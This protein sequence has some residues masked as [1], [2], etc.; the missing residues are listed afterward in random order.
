MPARVITRPTGNTIHVLLWRMTLR[1]DHR[2]DPPVAG[3][4]STTLLA[5]LNYQRE[6]LRWKC[7][8][9]DAAQLS[10]PLA[11]SSLTLAG[12]VKHLAVVE[13]GWLNLTFAGGVARPSWIAEINPDRP[14]WS[15]T[16]ATGAEPEQLFAWFEE[17]IEVSD[18]VIA[19]ALAS[20][21]G[22]DTL[23]EGHEDGERVSLRWILCHLLEEYARHN[24]HADLIR[25]S[26]DGLTGD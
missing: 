26:I 8:G 20:S 13:A 14:D 25:E 1:P 15:L 11:P 9:L 3:D 18:R 21:D 5:F 16:T 23:S 6:T 22:L 19:D 2:V 10:T 17:S 24:G 7:S 12:L 4:E